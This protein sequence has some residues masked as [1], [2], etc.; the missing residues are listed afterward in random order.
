MG[1]EAALVPRAALAGA[2]V[3][4]GTGRR[5]ASHDRT[6]YPL[7][8]T[9][10]SVEPHS[11]ERMVSFTDAVLA[12][13]MTL[14][15]L[16]LLESVSES[17]RERLDTLG[18][19]RE[20]NGQ[21]FAFG[22]SFFIIGLFW[23]RHHRLFDQVVRYTRGLFLLNLIWM[24]TIVWLPVATALVLSLTVPGLHFWSLLVL[25]LST[26]VEWLLRRKVR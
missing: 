15:I 10:Q 23:R 5:L 25:M 18:Y 20:H 3:G 7:I 8:M 9:R 19:L 1:V 4:L 13:A 16:P 17:A 11:V 26:P 24:F 14:L 21:L 6:G 12:I 22:L 2:G